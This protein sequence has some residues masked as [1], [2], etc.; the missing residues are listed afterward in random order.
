MLC[1]VPTTPAVSRATANNTLAMIRCMSNTP[2]M[3]GCERKGRHTALPRRQA[4]RA[5]EPCCCNAFNHRPGSDVLSHCLEKQEQCHPSLCH[6]RKES[7][8]ISARYGINKAPPRHKICAL[9]RDLGRGGLLAQSME[10]QQAIKQ[11]C[12]LLP[13]FQGALPIFLGNPGQGWG[14]E[15]KNAAESRVLREFAGRGSFG[16]GSWADT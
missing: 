3:I 1:C 8:Y 14:K 15:G 7:H 13:S 4:Q 2:V 16:I 5:L 10:N 12:D 9:P 11:S 6:C